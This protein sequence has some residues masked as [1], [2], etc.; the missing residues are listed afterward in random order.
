MKSGVTVGPSQEVFIKVK[1]EAVFADKKIKS[2][3]P[4]SLF[5]NLRSNLNKIELI[6]FLQ[7]KRKCYFQDENRLKNFRYYTLSN[8]QQE[9][10]GK[11]IQSKC[12]CTL[13][14]LSS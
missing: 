13:L 6:L 4:V 12:K 7:H 10:L 9:C 1:T 2:L 14:T 3:S 8:C 5:K 11:E